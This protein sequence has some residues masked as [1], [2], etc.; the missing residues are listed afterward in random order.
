MIKVYCSMCKTELKKSGALIFSPPNLMNM[1][2]KYH[3]CRECWDKVR[4]MIDG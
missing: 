2:R 3:L 4:E 1:V